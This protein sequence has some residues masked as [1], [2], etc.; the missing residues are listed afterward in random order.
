MKP[1]FVVF[2]TLVVLESACSRNSPQALAEQVRHIGVYAQT[3]SGALELTT[4]GVEE[5]QDSLMDGTSLAFRFSDTDTQSARA[6][7]FLVNMPDAVIAESKAY[8]LPDPRAAR[9]YTGR[10]KKTPVPVTASIENVAGTIYKVTPGQIPPDATG[11]LCLLVKMPAGNARPPVR[12]K[13]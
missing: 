8:V 7:A 12:D 9:W 13:A 5:H 4:Y 1:C 6:S 3:S 2:T 11:F 10:N